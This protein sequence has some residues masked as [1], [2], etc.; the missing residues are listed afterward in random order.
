MNN[1]ESLQQEID[2][3]IEARRKAARRQFLIFLVLVFVVAAGIITFV[4]RLRTSEAQLGT[5]RVDSRN[6]VSNA[7]KAASEFAQGNYAGAITDYGLALKYDPGNPTLLLGKGKALLAMHQY[8]SAASA[9]QQAYDNSPKTADINYNL[10]LAWWNMSA[11]DRSDAAF[12]LKCAFE[13]DPTLRAKAESDLAYL[14]ILK[15]PQ[16]STAERSGPCDAKPVRK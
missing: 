8:D 4:M 9:L 3:G 15:S 14:P 5:A 12:Q 7:V 11:P 10:A 2:K 16:F 13:H 1:A 6:T